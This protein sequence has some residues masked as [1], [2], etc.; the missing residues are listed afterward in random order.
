MKKLILV[1]VAAAVSFGCASAK[2]KS[3]PSAQ[4]PLEV[5]EDKPAF[6]FPINLSHLGSGGDADAMGVTVTAGVASNFGK[7]V[8]SGQ[9]LFDQVGNLSFDLAE[10]IKAQVNKGEWKMTGSAANTANELSQTMEKILGQLADK[11]LIPA[12]YKFRYIIAVHSHGSSTMGGTML[13]AESWGGVYDME[14][15][16]ILS[17]IESKDN[18]ANKPEAVMA[19]LPGTYNSIIQKLLNGK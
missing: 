8:V 11:G 2:I 1:A 19:S 5:T 9:Q 18:F 14:T 16:E 6:L 17:Y 10:Q 3:N 12:G 13:G 7:K 15:G 4:F